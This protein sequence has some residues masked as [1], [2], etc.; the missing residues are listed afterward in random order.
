MV[1]SLVVFLGCKAEMEPINFGKDQ[2][3]YCKMT[4]AD[5]KFGAEL[6]TEKGRV[7]KYDAAECLINH[8]QEVE[9]PKYQQL[10]VVAF[11]DPK[12]LYPVDSLHFITSPIYR[13]PMGAHLAA[14]SKLTS[15][16][17]S[18]DATMNWEQLQKKLI[19]Q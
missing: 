7:L 13:S 19:V 16:N 9:A 2:C 6:I 10:L 5:P 1:I 14:F 12:N 18:A 4:I 11:D 17:D 8:L 15:L 3:V